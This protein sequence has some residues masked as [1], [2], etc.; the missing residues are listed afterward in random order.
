[1]RTI[2]LLVPFTSLMKN[3]VDDFVLVAD[4]FCGLWHEL[5]NDLTEEAHVAAGIIANA[6]HEFVNCVFMLSRVL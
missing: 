4:V 3:D 2:D 6:G 5:V 1:L